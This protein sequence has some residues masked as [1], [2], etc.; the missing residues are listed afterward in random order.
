MDFYNCIR[1]RFEKSS[2]YPPSPEHIK[3][4]NAVIATSRVVSRFHTSRRRV[5]VGSLIKGI[6]TSMRGMARMGME[7]D[8][9]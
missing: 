9:Q 6:C 5:V 3:A 2:A 4:S 7:V 1:V 8:L